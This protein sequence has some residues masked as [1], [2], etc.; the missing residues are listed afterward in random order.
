MPPTESLVSKE[1]P[2]PAPSS[3][4]GRGWLDV[5][6]RI[7]TSWVGLFAAYAAAV[8]LALSN[9][10]KL[11]AG[12]AELGLPP[13]VGIA[14]LA[15][16]P[17][18][19]LVFSTIPSFLE[20]R[21]IKRYGEIKVDV[22]AG[23]FTLR[24]R[25]TEAEFE[26]VDKAHEQVLRWIENS[27]EPVLYLTGASGTGKS[28]LLAA[29]VIPKL[30]REG[31]VVI[32][33][34]GYEQLLERIKD[35]ILEPGLIWAQPPG[36]DVDLRSLL[37]RACQRL[38]ERR[39]ILAIDQFEE[40]LILKDEDHQRAFQEL[41]SAKMDNSAKSAGSL[42]FLLVFRPEYE[43]LIQDQGWPKL[44]LDTNRKVISAFTENAATEFLQKSGLTL[45]T[46]L[47]R[48]VMR[49]AAEIEQGSVGLI[50][51]VTINLCGLVL[52]R[53]S[54]GLPRRFRGGILRGFLR[55]SLLL[56]EVRDVAEKII[57]NLVTHNITKRS[58][59]VAE[60]AQATG[61]TAAAVRA[62]MR[63]LGES[64]RAIVRP[65]DEEQ[66]T[67]E[68]SH[69]FLVPLLDAIVA[70]RTVSLWRR[71]R[72]WLPWAAAGVV[73]A[74]A[75]AVPLM[76][77]PDPTT[78]LRK[79][80]WTISE[81]T[82]GLA[83]TFNRD[84]TI[85]PESI[86]ILRALP[87][88]YSLDLSFSDETD[89]SAF[90]ELKGVKALNLS[91]TDVNLSPLREL[92]SLTALDLNHTSVVE[93]SALQELKGLTTLDLSDSQVTDISALRD[94]KNMTTLNLGN[95]K[96]TNISALRELKSL[97]KLDLH[98]TKVTDISALRELKSLTDLDLSNTK[99]ENLSGLGE[100]KSL[101][102]LN[103]SNTK[104][105]EL[106][107]LRDMKSLTELYLGGTQVADIS[108]L[109]ELTGLTELDLRST[110]VRV[111]DVSALQRP[112]LE[113]YR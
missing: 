101:T 29:W 90:R 113:I 6:V 21:R 73:G 39:L 66:E 60:M 87:G 15:A 96:V 110:E 3:A 2:L 11:Q 45:N 51:P 79:Q 24:P 49:E 107:A 104:V 106:S 75:L 89:L 92:K 31:H 69:D 23:Y 70:R 27:K 12:F 112:G 34:R 88:P 78:E 76:T 4:S 85:P 82:E 26:R 81:T 59:T 77:K 65:L 33:L 74:V 100:L 54:S 17:L 42:T 83:F 18:V 71:A 13:W 58:R 20:Q 67:W 57:P 40:F 95:T 28:S 47:T 32:Q 97:T 63:R 25:E 86:A 7:A 35:R 10:K 38:G 98:L 41:L 8:T 43:G 62:C 99:V 46:D 94:L 105:V 93:I 30:I 9:V 91:F 55:E 61:L 111:R 109:R 52:S 16:L 14:L 68:I 22:T 108:V 1:A 19:A 50:R 103:L 72:P 44:K 53:F 36:R 56:P 37:E 80:G 48:A 84:T 64:D 5:T 102:T